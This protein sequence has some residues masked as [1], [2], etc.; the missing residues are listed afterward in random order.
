MPNED[1]TIHV[2]FNG[3]IYN[4]AALRRELQAAGHRFRSDHSDT[5]VLVHGWEQ[6]GAELPAKLTG[7]FAFAIFDTKSD[8][9]FL[10]RDRIGQKPL[11]YATLEDGI[12]FGSTL[13]SVLAW[14]EVP[15]RVPREQ[16]GL[17]LLL[18]YFP[19]PQTVYRDVSQVLP[20]AWLRVT[21]DV[22]DG[23]TYWQRNSATPSQNPRGDI[24][25]TLTAAV[26]SQLV[27]DVPVACFLSGGIDSSIIATLMQNAVSAAGGN[28]ITTVSVGFPEAR[29]DE[30][31]FAQVVADKIK[32][33]HIRLEVTPD[34]SIPDTLS[35]LMQ[36]TLGQPFADSS[37]LPTHYLAR[38]VRGIAPVA[39]SGDGA[40][41]LFGGYDRYRA[42]RLLSSWPR[43]ARLMPSRI[44]VGLLSSRERWRRLARASRAE[45]TAERYTR[46]VEIFDLAAI[47]KLLPNAVHDYFPEPIEYGADDDVSPMRFGML[48][49]QAEYLP[50]DTLWKVDCGAMAVALE[51]RAPFLDHNLVALAN[52]L[53]DTSLISGGVGKKILRDIFYHE[54][55]PTVRI[56]GKKGFGVPFG[57]YFRKSLRSALR[58]TL[59]AKDSFAAAHFHRPTIEGILAE[60][61][62]QQRDHTHRLFA[63]FMLELW[64]RTFRP[65]I[66]T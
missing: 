50:G 11:F 58:D 23:R 64:Y 31:A 1:G 15:R 17:Y 45:I 38:T 61:D 21:R 36:F 14:P 44:N 12:V 27:A 16:I 32:S 65:T 6:W 51:V 52:G 9:L 22:V 66:E 25:R 62:A 33:K 47:E 7:M 56:R 55:P 3:E 37:I 46:M 30:T 28:P 57:G 39:L 10:A 41:E 53:P 48:R 18:G 49:D 2:V 40:D 34:L 35:S 43:L 8:T 42:M 63:L 19:P 20:G 5:E 60:H 29:F 59:F 54:L 26:A 13:N 24:R 4:H